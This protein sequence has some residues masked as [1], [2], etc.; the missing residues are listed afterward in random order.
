M[1]VLLNGIQRK[2]LSWNNLH[3]KLWNQS[4]CL[5][6]WRCYVGYQIKRKWNGI[7]GCPTWS[8]QSCPW[9]VIVWL[10]QGRDLECG[11]LGQ[12][13]KV[14]A[15]F[16]DRVTSAS[17]ALCISA[18]SHSSC[19][20]VKTCSQFWHGPYMGCKDQS[21]FNGGKDWKMIELEAL[22]RHCY[23]WQ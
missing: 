22:C 4:I 12:Q 14:W 6:F 15:E 10:E 7:W 19:L 11:L 9:D 20:L 16:K 21:C 17:V 13:L 5:D 8:L 1:E 18:L 2:L 23:I 3:V